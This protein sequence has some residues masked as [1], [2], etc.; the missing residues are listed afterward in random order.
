M[1]VM[2]NTRIDSGGTGIIIAYIAILPHYV[3]VILLANR[4]SLFHAVVVN[5]TKREIGPLT[6][7]ANYGLQTNT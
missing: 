3:T 4:G 5:I 7:Q 1:P 6:G 2:L